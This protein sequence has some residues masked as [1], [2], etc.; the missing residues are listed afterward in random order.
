MIETS[1]NVAEKSLN[2]ANGQKEMDKEKKWPSSHPS[3]ELNYCKPYSDW[4]SDHQIRPG[5]FG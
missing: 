1:D 2:V 4:I 5:E 3:F